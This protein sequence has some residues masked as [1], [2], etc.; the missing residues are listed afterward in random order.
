DSAVINEPAASASGPGVGKAPVG[1]EDVV[2]DFDTEPAPTAKRLPSIVEEGE[3]RKSVSEVP[4]SAD[5]YDTRVIVKLESDPVTDQAVQRMQ[6]KHPDN[7]VVI[8]RDARGNNTVVAGDPNSISGRAKVELLGHHDTAPDGSPTLGG[9]NSKELTQEVVK[10]RAENGSAL[11][12]SKVTAV[13]CNTGTCANPSSVTGQLDKSLKAQGIETTVK[14]YEG[15]ISVN[16]QGSKHPVSDSDS[17]ALGKKSYKFDGGSSSKEIN[18]GEVHGINS[19]TVKTLGAYKTTG[20]YVF[21]NSGKYKIGT[22]VQAQKQLALAFDRDATV[23]SA[24]LEAKQSQQLKASYLNKGV[25]AREQDSVDHYTQ[26][27]S[28]YMNEASEALRNEGVKPGGLIAEHINNTESFINKMAQPSATPIFRVMRAEEPIDSIF[29]KIEPGRV[30]MGNGFL[31]TSLSPSLV[32]GFKG[33]PSSTNPLIYY[34]LDGVRSGANVMGVRS[35]QWEVLVQKNTPFVINSVTKTN[36]GNALFIS[37]SEGV[38]I[39][40]ST[41]LDMGLWKELPLSSDQ[42]LKPNAGK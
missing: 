39:P 8:E 35:D 21:D 13:G 24:S 30:M 33:T 1:T 23:P 15:S 38:N 26:Q 25:T 31:S 42:I 22:S 10:L 9:L 6:A 32:K 29:N 12:V 37:A 36:N 34:R 28:V 14:G 27:G 41:V 40:D 16:V 17:T 11:N 20:T 18:S 3:P 2:I 7:T 19:G 5:K 4:S